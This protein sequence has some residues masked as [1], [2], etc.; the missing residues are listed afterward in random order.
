[1]ADAVQAEETEEAHLNSSVE[2]H[3]DSS[4]EALLE[5]RQESEAAARLGS[6]GEA[7]LKHREAES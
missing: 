4:V 3:L 6:L 7:C 5:Q 1:M 2:A